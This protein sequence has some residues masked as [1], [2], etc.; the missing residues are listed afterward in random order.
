MED[1]AYIVSN[2]TDFMIFME[3]WCHQCR[4][5]PICK[6]LNKVMAYG[7]EAK[8]LRIKEGMPVCTSFSDKADRKNILPC[9]KT[10]DMF[11]EPPEAKPEQLKII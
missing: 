9:K 11:V 2:G 7:C 10:I 3:S 8:Q 5:E 4:V 1:E 6:I